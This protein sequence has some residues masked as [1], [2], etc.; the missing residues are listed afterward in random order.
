MLCVSHRLPA[1]GSD[2]VIK[3][4]NSTLSKS[5]WPPAT[6]LSFDNFEELSQCLRSL[7]RFAINSNAFSMRCGCAS[8]EV[9]K[10]AKSCLFGN[11]APTQLVSMSDRNRVF[12]SQLLE[13]SFSSTTSLTTPALRTLHTINYQSTRKQN[14]MSDPIA[15]GMTSGYKKFGRRADVTMSDVGDTT[16]TPSTR[17]TRVEVQVSPL[18][19]GEARPKRSQPARRAPPPLPR[20]PTP[21]EEEEQQFFVCLRCSKDP[22]KILECDHP[23]FQKCKPCADEHHEC[24]TVS[25]GPC[26]SCVMHA[27]HETHSSNLLLGA[28]RIRR[29]RAVLGLVCA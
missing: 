9:G 3:P 5:S 20:S 24:L 14:A 25:P 22:D 27:Y 13:N 26:F 28:G 16:P 18:D 1:T 8:H 29:L 23:R 12:V 19:E 11:V 2:P 15:S 7:K 17:R 10:F 4:H 21:E 6:I